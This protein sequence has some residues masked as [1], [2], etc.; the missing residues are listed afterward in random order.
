MKKKLQSMMMVTF[1]KLFV[2]RIVASKRSLSESKSL[3]LESAGCFRSAI[4]LKSAGESEKKAISEAE[5]KP[6]TIKRRPANTMAMIAD[7]VGVCTEIPLKT[8]ANWHK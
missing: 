2:M 5:A 1:T 6:D 8:S 3:I 7:T 4:V